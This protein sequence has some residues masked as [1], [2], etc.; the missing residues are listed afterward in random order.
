VKAAWSRRHDI[1]YS[2]V[3]VLTLRWEDDDLGVVTELNA[4][5][6]VFADLYHYEVQTYSIPSEKPDKAIKRRILDFL[7]HD[8]L[9]TL[10][11]LYY[12]GHAI[13]SVQVNEAPIWFA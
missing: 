7:E 5:D 11:I 9:E 10:L 6:H 13:S 2:K 8:G 12:A 3:Q 4:L 1:R